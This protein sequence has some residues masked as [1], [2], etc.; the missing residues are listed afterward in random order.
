LCSA[1]YSVQVLIVSTGNFRMGVSSNGTSWDKVI[2]SGTLALAVDDVYYVKL[3]WDGETYYLDYS[4]DNENWTRDIGVVSRVAAYN[5]GTPA[6][7][8][9]SAG[10]YLG[11]IDLNYTSFINSSG[12]LWNARFVYT[13]SPKGY[14]ITTPE[15]SQVVTNLY[16]LEGKEL[17]YILDKTNTQF[18]L[19]R[20]G[21]VYSYFYG[22]GE[23][24]PLSSPATLADTLPMANTDLSNISDAGRGVVTLGVSP[25][26][27]AGVTVYGY[28]SASNAFEAPCAGVIMANAQQPHFIPK[29]TTTDVFLYSSSV[30]S[31]YII[32]KGDKF[33]AN[34]FYHNNYSGNNKFY[35]FKGAL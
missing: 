1:T 10:P 8:T 14:Y 4:T 23:S 28:T 26:Y 30:I 18:K 11:D 29:G 2:Q 9:T 32:G 3:G 17:Y 7:I 6:Y 12:N 25:D 33:W 20:V 35:P 27:T 22:A 16:T 19:P 34:T 13:V 21:L 31:T 5:N 24:D 15:F